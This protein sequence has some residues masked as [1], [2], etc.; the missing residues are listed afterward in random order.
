MDSV[1]TPELQVKFRFMGCQ[2]KA[3]APVSVCIYTVRLRYF[4]NICYSFKKDYIVYLEY[5]EYFVRVFE[6]HR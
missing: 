2:V 5:L 1:T 6:E 4:G 3:N